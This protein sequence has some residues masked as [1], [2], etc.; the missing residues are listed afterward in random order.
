M[1]RS[2]LLASQPYRERLPVLSVTPETAASVSIP[3]AR[4]KSERDDQPKGDTFE[5]LVDINAQASQASTVQTSNLPDQH[6][7]RPDRLPN[8]SRLDRT[9]PND[10]NAQARSSRASS[11]LPPQTGPAAGGP[12]T[13]IQKPAADTEASDATHH[14][15]A[16]HEGT[17]VPTT[18]D[19]SGTELAASGA[20]A[21]D[22]TATL[23]LVPPPVAVAVAAPLAATPS[24]TTPAP[25]ATETVG[26][27]TES[28]QA[29]ALLL[30]QQTGAMPAAP[31]TTTAPA[32]Q[33]PNTPPVTARAEQTGTV[34][35]G[36]EGAA[37]QALAAAITTATPAAAKPANKAQGD[38]Q[39]AKTAS[40]VAT[41]FQTD[42]AA[43]DA[44]TPAPVGDTVAPHN[45][46][47]DHHEHDDGAA[48]TAKNIVSDDNGS[49]APQPTATTP[50]HL[51][52]AADAASAPQPGPTDSGQSINSALAQPQVQSAA[53][54][55]P[56]TSQYNVAVVAGAA[57][58]L[59]GLAVQIAVTALSGKS[60]F[61]IRLDPADLGRIDVRLDV[62]RQ[63]RV[64][65]HLTV[66]KPE[67]LAMLR[68]DAPQLQRA[69]Q[70]A[71][72]K[73]GDGGLQ[74]SLRDQSSQ[75]QNARDD[76]GGRHNQRL[77]VTEE[78]IPVAAG[79]DYGRILGSN[80]GLD[81][82][83]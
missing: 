71:G 75:Q 44:T 31:A 81:I 28:T 46:A 64:T 58:P 49:P 34:Q 78:N 37:S 57:V 35:T 52:Q 63:G 1:A 5:S 7:M 41:G 12:G 33:N 74:F 2:L 38:T 29:A 50:Q 72:L 6:N 9:L 3:K 11:G 69:L 47:P 70:D 40:A 67:T 15:R 61:E 30:A 36:F 26:S 39:F 54:T 68:Q 8:A 25:A 59:N 22:P 13:E 83:V 45:A 65:S 79:R 19:A 60:R 10:D 56:A 42:P 4:Q 18:E 21:T 80:G 53:A 55:T 73:T 66:E 20:T 32:V 24:T 77:I 51:A 62:D 82:R 27:A 14:H 43:V 48:T 76:T 16:K 17:K 23:Q